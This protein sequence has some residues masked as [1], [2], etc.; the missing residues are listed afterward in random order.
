MPQILTERLILVP[1][2]EE[3]L[4][5][6]L[7]SHEAFAA[8]LGVRV[9]AEWPPE[10]YDADAVRW[11]LRYLR[12][13]PEHGGWSLY[14]L[15]LPESAGHEATA[16]GA[17]GFKG[18]PD[19]RGEVELGYGVLPSFQRQGYATEAVRGMTRFAFGDPRVTTV[20]GQTIPSLVGSIGGLEQAG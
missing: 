14:Y 8:A 19:S 11:M 1:G 5:A 18:P 2:A 7:E 20:V 6:E 13:N 9:P 3:H 17:S 12:E 15:T 10:F 4:A 16:I